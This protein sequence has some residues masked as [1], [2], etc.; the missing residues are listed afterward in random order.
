MTEA[1][2]R[3]TPHRGVLCTVHRAPRT[4]TVVTAGAPLALPAVAR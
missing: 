1:S 2:F 4:A 3:A